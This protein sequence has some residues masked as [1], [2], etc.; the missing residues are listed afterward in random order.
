M[1]SFITRLLVRGV[2][3]ILGYQQVSQQR[4][5]QHNYVM[6]MGMWWSTTYL[7]FMGQYAI[8]YRDGV[9]VWK[10]EVDIIAAANH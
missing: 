5:A 3:F 1:I 7:W 10:S 2:R 4:D 6:V 8:L 9:Y